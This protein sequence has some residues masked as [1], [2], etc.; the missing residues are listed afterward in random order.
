MTK[1]SVTL[2][3]KEGSSDKV[4]QASIE[5]KGDKFV[6]N[7]AYGRRGTALNA[8][9]KTDS[10][11]AFDEAKK[12]YDKLLREKTAKG[13]KPGEGE[14]APAN[15]AAAVAS[16]EERDTGLRP[17]LLNP[18]EETGAIIL[19]NDPDFW[20]QEKFNGKRCL[21]KKTDDEVI[22]TNRMGLAV[23]L[24]SKVASAAKASANNF[25]IDGELL[26]DA[27]VAF[28][29]LAMDGRD[30]RSKPYFDRLPLLNA[31][32]DIEGVIRSAETALTTKD[33]LGLYEQLKKENAEG[34]VF[35][36]RDAKYS[37]GRPNTGG[38]QLKFKFYATCSA[39]VVEGRAGKRSVALALLDGKSEVAVGNVTVPANQAIPKV[40]Q[41]I[42][43]RY[44][45]AHKGGSL[46]QPTL[47]GVRDD[48]GRDA[49]KLS[50]LKY[51]QENAD[52]DTDEV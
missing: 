49:C 19:L 44:L 51:I 40:G 38:P 39:I 47:L 26:G 33:K 50:Q 30:L 31:L 42:E 24:P 36:R 4:Y 23:A 7:F 18:I 1:E 21:L 17:Q 32:F 52:T 35:K 2:Y 27:L 12:I 15:V 8:G 22:G 48:V 28:D 43:V 29:V 14:E 45:Y 37:A 20:A 11:V 3:F 34:I 6:V 16:K 5:E 41:I 46:Y 13:Y 9:T 10:P 25:V